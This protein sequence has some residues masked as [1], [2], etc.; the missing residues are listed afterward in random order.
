MEREEARPATAEECV[1]A[2]GEPQQNVPAGEGIWDAFFRRPGIDMP[3]R[4][5]PSY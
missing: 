5:Q 1:V 3:D 4:D 2:S